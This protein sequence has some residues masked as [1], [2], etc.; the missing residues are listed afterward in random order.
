MQKAMHL[1]EQR[2][3][4]FIDIARSVGYESD[5]VFSK[6]FK[7]VVGSTLVNISKIVL[8]TKVMPES[9]MVFEADGST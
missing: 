6:A 1:L 4:K 9:R 8:K 5:A 7:R 3:K 2:D